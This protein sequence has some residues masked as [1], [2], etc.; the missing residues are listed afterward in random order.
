MLWRDD[1]PQAN[2]IRYSTSWAFSPLVL[3]L[4]RAAISLYAF[5]TLFTTIGFEVA[6]GVAIAAAIEFGRSLALF[7]LI[8]R[9]RC[10]PFP[11][12][13]SSERSLICC[14]VVYMTIL[15]YWAL[16]FYFAFAAAHSLSYH[17]SGGTSFLQRWSK[18]L[19]FAH[20]G[21][22]ATITVLPFIVTIVFWTVLGGSNALTYPFAVW[23]NISEHAL[24][25]AFALFEIFMTSTNPTGW[26]KL[27]VIII[28][29]A[30]YLAETYVFYAASG[31][32]VYPFLNPYVL[33]DQCIRGSD[34]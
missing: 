2:A 34:D 21:L 27:L 28:V 20:G 1:D 12:L 25:S 11:C 16:A 30:L 23:N 4:I 14:L 13:L 17:A 10:Q 24:N 8:R 33:E 7:D 26:N 6:N 9:S 22:Y 15:N 32:Y 31:G 3:G 5:T 29:L 19:I 18:W